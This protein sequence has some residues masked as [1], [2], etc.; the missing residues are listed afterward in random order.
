MPQRYQQGGMGMRGEGWGEVVLALMA[1]VEQVVSRF[2][3]DDLTKLCG[4][5]GHKP[6]QAS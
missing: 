4:M 5:T 1:A 6:F 3:S 2:G